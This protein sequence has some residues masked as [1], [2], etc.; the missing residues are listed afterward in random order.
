MYNWCMELATIHFDTYRTV[1]L[2]QDHGFSEEQ[3]EGFMEAMRE[4]TLTGVATKQNV[5][6]V[7]DELK[8]D[9]QDLRDEV[10]RDVQ[11]ILKFQIVQTITF[12]GV[13]IALFALFS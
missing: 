8:Q 12:V 4:I 11:G 1:K 13:M 6:D 9:I 5:Q 7:R 10:R 3:A 2:L